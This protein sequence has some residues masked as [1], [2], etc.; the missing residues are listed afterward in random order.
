MSNTNITH[1]DKLYIQSLESEASRKAKR[2]SLQY[3]STRENRSPTGVL[4]NENGGDGTEHDGLTKL[5]I[6]SLKRVDVRAANTSINRIVETP[7]QRALY[8][9][10]TDM[11]DSIVAKESRKA[12]V[13]EKPEFTIAFNQYYYAV[14][15][16]DTVT[17]YNYNAD[18]LK[19]IFPRLTTEE[20]DK[21]A[22]ASISAETILTAA[23]LNILLALSRSDRIKSY[24]ERN[25]YYRM[26]IGL[27][28][29]LAT[30]KDYVYVRG[31]K[32]H[33]LPVDIFYEITHS[34][35]LDILIAENADKQ[36]I[37]FINRDID[38][39]MARRAG[40]FDI[41][42]AKNGQRYNKYRECYN[43][44]KSVY[45]RTIHSDFLTEITEYTE[46]RELT[47]IKIQA[48]II[49][50]LEISSRELDRAEY[51][52]EAAIQIWSENGLSF[53]KKMPELY[54]N[55]TTL[56]LNYLISIK[57]TNKVLEY[58][59]EKIFSG[60][61]LYKYFIRKT[62][63]T[64][65][66]FPLPEGM[67]PEEF[68]NIEFV[69]RP[70]YAHNVIDFKED[71]LDDR[72]LSYEEV[73]SMDPRWRDTEELKN[74]VLNGDFS[75]VPSKYISLNNFIDIG[76]F[77]AMYGILTNVMVEHR[78]L[79]EKEQ[80]YVQSASIHVTMFEA[81]VYYM[82]LM[83]RWLEG[84]DSIFPESLSDATKIMGFKIPDN[85][86]ELR[87]LFAWHFSNSEYSDILNEM[88]DAFDTNGSFYS[89]LLNLDRVMAMD[90]MFS[91]ILHSARSH[92][93]YDLLED[94]FS[95]IKH[96]KRGD[97]YDVEKTVDGMT[98]E[99]WLSTNCTP[100]YATYH[101]IS[102][103]KDA[104]IIEMDNITTAIL[105]FLEDAVAPNET[106]PNINKTFSTF[107]IIVNGVSKYLSFILN[108]LKA[109][110]CQFLNDEVT[111][112]Y[113]GIYETLLQI[114]NIRV[115][116]T[117][118]P[119]IPEYYSDWDGVVIQLSMEDVIR[120]KF[121]TETSV[122]LVTPTGDIQI[123]E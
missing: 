6:D 87:V 109:Y 49:F 115:D 34:G 54:R 26:L 103:D 39:I 67:L 17:E 111:Y 91:E 53:P 81:M 114:P 16:T 62:H 84:R 4:L 78:Y 12:M 21:I 56:L 120:D 7:E 48:I 121:T 63:R 106:I 22:A 61:T 70:I 29:I 85:M 105:K 65:L 66:T 89:F 30:E 46:S 60:I 19:G 47:T 116:A 119:K 59:T 71:E 25:D 108:M 73:V 50:Q 83:Q 112:F 15:Q 45:M 44:E 8:E 72:S 113:S 20:C 80:L 107:N 43:K 36:Y 110:S 92:L 77:S 123:G 13:F 95:L 99:K 11:L 117:Y 31:H 28:S 76:E 51:T 41:L 10:I 69:L 102:R 9:D 42:W 118:T 98:Y 5:E 18:D 90:N 122:W 14:S 75:C 94:L 82:A 1:E 57:G 58:I 68:Y 33:E 64:G 37:S 55:T 38:I 100:L 23:E 40:T 27:P 79:I 3:S 74:A 86:D 88:P 32:I 93:E 35:E 2:V 52:E 101:N 96:V 104:M 97:T 24:V